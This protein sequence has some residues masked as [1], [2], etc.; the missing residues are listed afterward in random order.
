MFLMEKR[1]HEVDVNFNITLTSIWSTV[2][3]V[4]T[5]FWW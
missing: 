2:C 1:F 3:L 5:Y 4:N